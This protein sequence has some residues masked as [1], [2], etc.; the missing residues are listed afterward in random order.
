MATSIVAMPKRGGIHP[1]YG[2]F[3]GGS[4]L[5]NNYSLKSK[6]PYR[7]TTQLRN[8]KHSSSSERILI[9]ARQNASSI[10]FKGNLDTPV[11][12]TNEYDKE[13]FITALEEQISFYGLQNLFSIP[14]SNGVMRSL[15]QDSHLFDLKGVI[16]EFD[17]R[18][19][20]PVPLFLQDSQGND[21]DVESPESVSSRL[22][23]YDDYEK[24]DIAF[25]RLVIEA[26]I[27]PTY[28]ETV[29]QDS[30]TIKISRTYLLRYT[31]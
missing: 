23:A 9:S 25:S 7:L 24:Y 14:D 6:T 28:R 5:T 18:M 10:T 29:K 2:L 20:S 22:R 13:G 19:E 8:P 27:S 1:I 16:I 12:C 26:L 31:S 11:N 15:V 17:S 30:L 4:D 21:T 3:M